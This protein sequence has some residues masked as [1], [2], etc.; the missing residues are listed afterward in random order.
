MSTVYVELKNNPEL[1]RI[2]QAAFPNYKKRTASFRVFTGKRNV[3][4]YWDGGSRSE[5]VLI[6]LAT[7]RRKPLPTASHPFY[8]ISS[9]GLT[10]QKAEAIET[11]HVGN[12]YLTE[13]PPGFALVEAGTFCGKPATAHV[14]FNSENMPKEIEG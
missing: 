6:E 13:L 3:N 1:K 2:I 9:K 4:S 5:F 14:L 11:D 12:V 7:M 8:D 10:N